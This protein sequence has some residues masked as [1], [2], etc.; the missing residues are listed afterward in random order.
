MRRTLPSS[1]ACAAA[2]RAAPTAQP[3]PIQPITV[4][5]ARIT[6]LAPALAAVASSVRTTV[7]TAK[8]WRSPRMRVMQSAMSSVSSM[9]ILLPSQPGQRVLERGE[10]GEIVRRSEE[11]DMRQGRGHAGGDRGVVAPAQHRVEPD[12][13][14]RAP[15]D[16]G[17]LASERRRIARVLAV[18]DDD[19]HGMAVQRATRVA[20]VE[21]GQAGADARAAFPAGGD[22]R[23]PVD[24]PGCVALAQGLGDMDQP[25]MEDEGV[26][27]GEPVDNAADEAHEE[28][29]VLAHR[30]ADVEHDDEAERRLAPAPR[31]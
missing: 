22:Q 5:S 6:A 2:L 4:P 31:D 17:E 11:I 27:A 24:R 15:A 28:G 9:R 10:A 26:G 12:N 30:A 16:L 1:S 18:A 23:E 20:T 7:A 13:T 19:Y 8:G 3:P 21:F 14:A 25:G 29:A